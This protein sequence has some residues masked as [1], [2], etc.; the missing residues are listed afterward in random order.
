MR[1]NRVSMQLIFMRDVPRNI[2]I[3][4]R[5]SGVLTAS[6]QISEK[7]GQEAEFCFPEF[8]LVVIFK[9]RLE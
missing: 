4:V 2:S 8:F 1:T 7:S 6:G 3:Q 5:K 9:F